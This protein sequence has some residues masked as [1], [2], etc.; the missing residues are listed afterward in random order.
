[1]VKFYFIAKS[2]K[3]LTTTVE[4]TKSQKIDNSICE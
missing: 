3:N 4:S 2:K 1:M